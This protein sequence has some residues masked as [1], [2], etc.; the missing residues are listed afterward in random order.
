[1]WTGALGELVTGLNHYQLPQGNK[2]FNWSIRSKSE[3][4]LSARRCTCLWFSW[5]WDFTSTSYT[6]A[7]LMRLLVLVARGAGVPSCERMWMFVCVVSLLVWGCWC[8]DWCVCDVMC[9]EDTCVWSSVFL[10][11]PGHVQ[12]PTIQQFW[13]VDCIN[14]NNSGLFPFL[15]HPQPRRWLQAHAHHGDSRPTRGRR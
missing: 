8:V 15:S 10:S 6:C 7:A 3:G 14:L 13:R 11:W 2:L 5:G 9:C 12:I 4:S 1:M